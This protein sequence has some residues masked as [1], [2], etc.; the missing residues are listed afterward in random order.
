MQHVEEDLLPNYYVGG[1]FTLVWQMTRG[2]SASCREKVC[3]RLWHCACE[4]GT[5]INLFLGILCIVRH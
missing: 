5:A 3:A 4:V 2:V 1:T